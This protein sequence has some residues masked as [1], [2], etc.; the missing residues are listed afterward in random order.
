MK[1]FIKLAPEVYVKPDEVISVERETTYKD[2]SPSPSD[3]CLI[4]DFDGSRVI[5]KNGRKI[6]IRDVFPDAILKMLSTGERN[7]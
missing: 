3:S 5:L 6:Y 1:N 4:K 7:G 2:R